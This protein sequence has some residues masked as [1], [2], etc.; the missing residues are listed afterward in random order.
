MT[1]AFHNR[2]PITDYNRYYSDLKTKKCS[3]EIPRYTKFKTVY[4][5]RLEKFWKNLSKNIASKK[6]DSILWTFWLGNTNS[7]FWPENTNSRFWLENTN[8]SFWLDK[9]NSSFRLENIN[10]SFWLENRIWLENTRAL[11]IS[12]TSQVNWHIYLKI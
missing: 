7:S 1:L 11:M 8:S 4:S 6:I 2:L 10:S 5:E 9:T 12:G 3:L